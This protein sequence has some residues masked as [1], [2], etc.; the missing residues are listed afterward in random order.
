MKRQLEPYSV[1]GFH[2]LMAPDA[3]RVSARINSNSKSP[4]RNNHNDQ[5][6]T[7]TTT[8]RPQLQSPV[9]HQHIPSSL[10]SSTSGATSSSLS[11]PPPKPLFSEL[12]PHLQSVTPLLPST[13]LKPRARFEQLL[14]NSFLHAVNAKFQNDGHDDSRPL[15]LLRL[16][17]PQ[18]LALV[19]D[20]ST[21]ATQPLGRLASLRRTERMQAELMQIFREEEKSW[22]NLCGHYADVETDDTCLASSSH[23]KDDE[24]PHGVDEQNSASSSLQ[25]PI[26][27]IQLQIEKFERA[28]RN[29]RHSQLA[30]EQLNQEAVP[31]LSQ[32]NA[33]SMKQF[34]RKI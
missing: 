27:R 29:V 31:K 15:E 11:A 1:D 14:E 16:L 21:D 17:Q 32:K 33:N 34:F 23:E 8:P 28:L 13:S 7:S 18:F 9:R 24:P 6:T 19:H 5:P 20:A 22:S 10:T 2:F 26:L 30:A 4:P 12:P 3:R 25:V